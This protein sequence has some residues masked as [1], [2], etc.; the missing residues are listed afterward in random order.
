[1]SSSTPS[2]KYF[3]NHLL[4]FFF[5][6]DPKKLSSILRCLHPLEAPQVEHQNLNRPSFSLESSA[7]FLFLHKFFDTCFSIILACP[8]IHL[9]QVLFLK[10]SASPLI[11]FPASEVLV[12]L[13]GICTK[14]TKWNGRPYD[15]GKVTG[16]AF[17]SWQSYL[18]FFGRIV[19]ALAVSLMKVTLFPWASVVRVPVGWR[20]G[21]PLASRLFLR[22]LGLFLSV[23]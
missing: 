16:K 21:Q 3:L 13:W 17:L 14:L 22:R 4:S 11:Y 2:C 9:F 20:V 1:M 19:V 7:L 6:Q 10:F 5:L 18:L 8:C 15:A 12:G 23:C